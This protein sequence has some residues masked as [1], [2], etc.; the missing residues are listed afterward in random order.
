MTF[1]EK[2]TLVLVLLDFWIRGNDH[3]RGRGRGR[4]DR[5]HQYRRAQTIVVPQILHW[6]VKVQ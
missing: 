1:V 3:D 2:S 5:E 6:K 4:D